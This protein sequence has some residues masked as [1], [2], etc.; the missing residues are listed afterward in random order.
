MDRE[1][2][3]IGRDG[4]TLIGFPIP[5][6]YSESIPI[7]MDF[8]NGIY[9]FT[10]SIES[11]VD[12][13]PNNPGDRIYLNQVDMFEVEQFVSPI[14]SIAPAS[15]DFGV[16]GELDTSSFTF[17]LSNDG[18][19]SS[20]LTIDAASISGIGAGAY[21]AGNG[22]DGV[23]LAGGDTCSV[24]VTFNPGSVG[25]FNAQLDVTSDAGDVAAALTAQSILP[26]WS[27]SFD[28]AFDEADWQFF[29]FDGSPTLGTPTTVQI[30]GDFLQ[31]NDPTAVFAGGFIPRSFGQ[32]Q[33]TALINADGT[34]TGA[35]PDNQIDQGVISHF[36]PELMHGYSAYLRYELNFQDLVLVKF[37][38]TNLDPALIDE[39]V[40]I[41]E[42]SDGD[43]SMDRMYVVELDVV[44]QGGTA[45]LIARAFDATTGD[46]MAT[47]EAEDTTPFGPGFAGLS[48]ITNSTGVNG[49]FD[50]A[51]AVSSFALADVSD[52][53]IDFGVVEAFSDSVS[54]S[55]TV[56]NGGNA[57]LLIS[58]L[59]VAATDAGDFAFQN[60][61][62][63]DPVPAG[64]SCSFE[65][66]FTPGAATP[67]QAE[68]V[69]ESNAS[70]SPDIIVLDGEGSPAPVTI[71][72]ADLIQVFD[73]D[74]KAATVLTTPP[75][76][77]VAVTYDGDPAEPVNAGSYLLEATTNDPDYQVASRTGVFVIEP[78]SAVL[79]LSDTTQVFD[80]NPKPVTV[81]T[82]PA[83]LP[84]SVT[85]NGNA[86]VPSAV[87]SYSVSASVTDPNWTGSVSG[88]LQI[89]QG[90][91]DVFIDNLSQVFD[92]TPR[93]VDV[94]TIPA[95]LNV[96]VTYE[97]SST[98]PVDA[99]S[100]AVVASVSDPSY[101]G[102]SS[103]T[104]VV[105]PAAAT[106]V[107]NDLVQTYDGAPKA[108]SVTTTPLGLS[109]DVTYDGVAT[110]PVDVGDFDVAVN[111]T[112]PNYTG[113]AAA[114]LLI[115][116]GT[117]TV[118]FPA[119][120]DRS[121][122]DS[123]FTLS[124]TASSGLAVS[125]NLVSGPATLVGDEVTLTGV[126]GEV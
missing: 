74:P 98:A 94:T 102:S 38:A 117:Q 32:S 85:Y 53:L 10:T 96:V 22:C 57:D 34:N 17:T 13:D 83:G 36:Q 31:I 84:V 37:D 20:E 40:R 3:F 88:L 55:V 115:E 122:N 2:Y 21:F 95:G 103:N 51:S 87:G 12:G 108:V 97:G 92:G 63:S 71:Q 112:D 28:G 52:E 30:I 50:T 121:V 86:T 90:T 126:L 81:T 62:C 116:P 124:A 70:T 26:D 6:N 54:E 82:D 113:S 69:I 41:A 9:Q 80:G 29:T 61:T 64:D 65:V 67:R 8:D 66:V 24:E 49:T 107:L 106:V 89:S 59:T 111:V 45:R 44:D 4:S 1:D 91:A 23:L 104:L 25:T 48:V 119:L 5:S 19:S 18:S 76:V 14:L 93:V 125:F 99:G 56:T 16:I 15:H 109:F 118:D 42:S 68:I 123:P 105:D 77:S 101:M 43:W 11:F 60:D 46:L 39:R 114:E 73:G 35:S 33:V 7:R 100:Y 58:S 120:A 110:V 27:D 75:G 47:V 78:G 79:S 72:F